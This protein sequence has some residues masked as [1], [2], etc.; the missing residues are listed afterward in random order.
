MCY[1]EAWRFSKCDST[2]CLLLMETRIELLLWIGL[3]AYIF[4]AERSSI[5]N[6]VKFVNKK[7]TERWYDNWHFLL[8]IRQRITAIFNRQISKGFPSCRVERLL[9]FC[10][11]E[12]PHSFH[13]KHQHEECFTSKQIILKLSWGGHQL[14]RLSNF[15][16][17]QL[18]ILIP[19]GGSHELWDYN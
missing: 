11:N 13:D 17:E 8:R 7:D 4:L 16:L 6:F 5:C 2:R 12:L 18:Q 15:F 3:P 10:S 14:A 19:Y 1:R 9:V